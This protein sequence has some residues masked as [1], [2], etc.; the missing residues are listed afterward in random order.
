MRLFLAAL[1]CA[2]LICAPARA[3]VPA[4]DR[5]M[6]VAEEAF[7]G[8]CEPLRVVQLHEVGQQ[9]EVL[10]WFQPWDC[11]VAF[12][13]DVHR[14]RPL[15][16]CAVLV[17]EVGHAAGYGHSADPRDVMYPELRNPYWGC[18]KLLRKARRR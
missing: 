17:H 16:V 5:Y 12:P 11:T 14:W 6:P 8:H 4:L 15:T 2:L 3:H 13:V 10:A 1:F 18:R 9:P 7:P